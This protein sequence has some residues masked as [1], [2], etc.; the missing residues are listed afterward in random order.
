[1]RGTQI[2]ARFIWTV[3]TDCTVLCGGG[4]Y[5]KPHLMS[6]WRWTLCEVT[7]NICVAVL[8]M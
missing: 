2:E 7:L 8:F 3:S 5:V 4:L 1:M 6:V